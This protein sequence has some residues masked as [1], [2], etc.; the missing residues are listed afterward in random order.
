MKRTKPSPLSELLAYL[1][2]RDGLLCRVKA[3][4]AALQSF[5]EQLT[6]MATSN[7]AIGTQLQQALTSL[8]TANTGLTALVGEITSIST[9]VSALDAL[10]QQLQSQIASG[11]STLNPADQAL[12]NQIVSTSATVAGQTTS[13]ATQASAI[14]VAPPTA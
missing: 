11:T 1:N 7:D 5:Q 8:Q 3:D 14:S 12:L 4:L 13:A 2:G 6:K 9:G 10:I